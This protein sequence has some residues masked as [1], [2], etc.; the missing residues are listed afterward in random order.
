MVGAAHAH[1]LSMF[2][3]RGD[4]DGPIDRIYGARVS[5]DGTLLDATPIVIDDASSRPTGDSVA[6]AT[7][8][9]RFFVVWIGTADSGEAQIFGRHVGVDGTPIESEPV[10]LTTA[11]HFQRIVVEFGIDEY[12]L[13]FEAFAPTHSVFAMI[14]DRDGAPSSDPVPVMEFPFLAEEPAVAF[15]GE[16]FYV[17]F[18]STTARV[19]A[20][21]RAGARG[22][23]VAFDEPV[24]GNLR[25]AF[26]GTLV[27]STWAGRDDSTSDNVV[28]AA[29]LGAAGQVGDSVSF[30]TTGPPASGLSLTAVDGQA[31]IVW[32]QS[33]S[34]QPVT[35]RL[36][37]PE[38]APTGP[39]P[40]APNWVPNEESNPRA[41]MSG[42][43]IAFTWED[44]RGFELI[45]T[46]E[47]RP[48]TVA[49]VIVDGAPPTEPVTIVPQCERPRIGVGEHGFLVGC[50]WNPSG[51]PAVISRWLG[52]DGAAAE[53]TIQLALTGSLRE[54]L[55]G[56]GKM[57]ALVST[58]GD[59][60]AV[61]VGEDRVEDTAVL[62]DGSVDSSG[63]TTGVW[64]GESFLIAH[65]DGLQTLTT[66]VLE[67]GGTSFSSSQPISTRVRGNLAV[68]S[69][70]GTNLVV[71]LA[72][73]GT[74]PTMATRRLE[75]IRVDGSG[76]PMDP[77][78]LVLTSEFE[79]GAPVPQAGFDGDRFWVAWDDVATAGASSVAVRIGTD[80][81][82]EGPATAPFDDIDDARSVSFLRTAEALLISY[83]RRD[84]TIGATD[85]VR[86]QWVAS[87]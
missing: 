66:N 29:R 25:L 61:W 40:S 78:P 34:A 16:Q 74:P 46:G 35:A 70:N 50:T 38:D 19:S 68:A 6:I 85:R 18:I 28:W 52:T 23:T 22:N 82:V 86:A 20:V 62:V 39:T 64:T 77:A 43:A 80:G 69:G 56:G 31:L 32:T 75:A 41:A 5:D 54:I 15:D 84:L 33:A 44:T 48:A 37:G 8:G 1:D 26:D 30:A 73:S 42:N 12:L 79:H 3:W 2:V 53:D 71:W 58:A 60:R 63:A 72:D 7:D 13:A 47:R 49:S 36:L 21:S 9:D 10:R 4:V 67:P 24:D 83:V 81:V 57:L 45:E 17:G 14:V 76:T 65:F 11:M 87:E 55:A 59:L 27:R 51:T